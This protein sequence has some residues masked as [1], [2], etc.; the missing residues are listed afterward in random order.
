MERDFLLIGT[1]RNLWWILSSYGHARSTVVVAVNKGKGKKVNDKVKQSKIPGRW[2][3]LEE[4]N[5]VVQIVDNVRE[6]VVLNNFVMFHA[7]QIIL[8]NNQPA[9]T[10]EY[11]RK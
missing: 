1:S 3:Q 7:F 4:Y 9:V 2:G 6:K 8:R 11:E 10:F 5:G